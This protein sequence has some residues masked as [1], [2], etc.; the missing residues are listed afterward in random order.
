LKITQD[1][2]KHKFKN[3][4]SRRINR[5]LCNQL[6]ID[7]NAQ[8]EFKLVKQHSDSNMIYTQ[9]MWDYLMRMIPARMQSKEINELIKAILAADTQPES[10][11]LTLNDYFR[12][13]DIVFFQSRVG[14]QRSSGPRTQLK[15]KSRFSV[16]SMWIQEY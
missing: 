3:E 10:A 7:A 1:F 16:F 15:N 6:T 12:H 2:V 9:M 11:V 13:I 5:N 14:N 8:M 4:T